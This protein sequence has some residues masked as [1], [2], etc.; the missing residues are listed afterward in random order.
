RDDVGP[1]QHRRGQ[2]R[3]GDPVG[4]DVTAL[5]EP[6]LVVETEDETPLVDGRAHPVQLA[7]RLVRRDQVLIAVLDP[8]ARPVERQRGRADQHI[9]R[10]ELPADPE[11]AADMAFVQMDPVARE[12][13]HLRQGLAV[14]MR[15]LGGAVEAQ[16]PGCRLR[17][18][19]GAASFEGYA[20]MP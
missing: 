2:I 18:G 9:F 3:Y 7:A 13:E 17:Y 12:A 11:A 8:F 5:V 1:R 16:Y 19:N 6:E 4:A 15:H 10:I 14:V 20:G